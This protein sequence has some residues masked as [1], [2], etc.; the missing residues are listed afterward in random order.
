VQRRREGDVVAPRPRDELDADRQALGRRAAA[1]GRRRP[2]RQVRRGRVARRLDL[3]GHV[4]R[5]VPV[6]SV[7]RADAEELLTVT[8]SVQPVPSTGLIDDK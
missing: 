1:H 2:A 5:P 8:E 7:I 4:H 6:D 3:A